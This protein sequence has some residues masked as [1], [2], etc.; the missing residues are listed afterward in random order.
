MRAAS[1]DD[2]ALMMLPPLPTDAAF[3]SDT[4]EAMPYIYSCAAVSYACCALRRAE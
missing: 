1:H 4:L 2:A 3:S